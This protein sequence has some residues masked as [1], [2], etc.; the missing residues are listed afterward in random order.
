MAIAPL[1]SRDCYAVQNWHPCENNF[2]KL[3]KKW[4]IFKE[5]P[6]ANGTDRA[7]VRS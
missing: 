3:Y 2:I 6:V 7:W 5:T 1:F 4:L